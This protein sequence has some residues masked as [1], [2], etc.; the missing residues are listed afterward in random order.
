MDK[1]RFSIDI[2]SGYNLI[3]VYENTLKLVVKRGVSDMIESKELTGGISFIGQLA[4]NIY[5]R[6]TVGYKWPFKIEEYND[7]TWNILHECYVDIR[8]EYS[9]LSRKLTLDSFKEFDKP[10]TKIIAALKQKFNISDLGNTPQTVTQDA[11]SKLLTIYSLPTS[12][13]Q[14]NYKTYY[15]IEQ[16]YTSPR[17]SDTRW[18]YFYHVGTTGTSPNLI[19]EYACNSFDYNPDLDGYDKIS[20]NGVNYWVIVTASGDPAD[21]ITDS[22][23]CKR[24]YTLEDTIAA[25]SESIN[26]IRFSNIYGNGFSANNILIG[27]SSEFKN[28]NSFDLELSLSEIFNLIR[29]IYCSAW[30]VDDGFIKFIWKPL[31][32]YNNTI[33][34]TTE[35]LNVDNVDYSDSPAPDTE[36]FSFIDADRTYDIYLNPSFTSSFNY[37]TLNVSYFEKGIPT[38]ENV[39]DYSLGFYADLLALKKNDIESN[40]PVLISYNITNK[41]LFINDSRDYY[42][43]GNALTFGGKNNERYSQY[44]PYYVNN[45]DKSQDYNDVPLLTT[46][47]RPIY[48]IKYN[49]WLNDY[50][51]LSLFTRI[52]FNNNN[53]G[54]LNSYEID[55]NTGNALFYIRFKE[56]N[57]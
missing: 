28:E 47:T 33:D 13:T 43:G 18:G 26:N 8:G 51:T 45:P 35:T 19:H 5:S 9:R 22:V 36:F 29:I 11:S 14:T 46:G 1:F 30:Y 17:Y 50:S 49:K 52:L 24:N 31:E 20:L 2:G 7:S 34:W 21:I 44:A 12:F 57:L 38:D 6:R 53:E 40:K 27:N 15:D 3:D 55:M 37:S 42:L 56:I 48:E 10:E 25:I 16:K 32:F 4:E 54:I 39:E 41:L 23:I